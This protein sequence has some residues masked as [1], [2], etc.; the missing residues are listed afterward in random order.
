MLGLERL[1]TDARAIDLDAFN[2]PAGGFV[3][4]RDAEYVREQLSSALL[5]HSASEMEERLSAIGVAA[6]RVRRLGEFLDE[7]LDGAVRLPVSRFG[8]GEDAV[9][10]PG[11]G[12]RFARHADATNTGAETLGQS[13][14]AI[15]RELGR[16]PEEV[17]RLAA[18]GVIII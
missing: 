13:A 3:V 2:A 4:P 7:A 14:R 12:F 16:T 10:T 1:C 5:A 9:R 15:L 8:E 18:A 17:D 6:A 11:L